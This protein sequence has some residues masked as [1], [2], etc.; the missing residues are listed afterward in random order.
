MKTF[1]LI[2]ALIIW[3]SLISLLS[4]VLHFSAGAAPAIVTPAAA[5]MPGQPLT[6]NKLNCNYSWPGYPILFCTAPDSTFVILE[7]GHVTSTS[8]IVY[9]SGL[10]AGDLIAAWGNPDAAHP[11]SQRDTTLYWQDKSAFV[12]MGDHFSPHS[13]VGF[14]RYGPEHAVIGQWRGFR[15]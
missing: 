8:V 4:L 1:T 9:G 14:V 11:D 5:L 12:F 2:P 10:S 3:L 13:L 15:R 7:A 6:P